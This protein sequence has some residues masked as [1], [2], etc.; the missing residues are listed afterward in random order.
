MPEHAA[1]VAA[2]AGG[3]GG[4]GAG[5]E[6]RER[7]GELPFGEAVGV[8]ARGGAERPAPGRGMSGAGN[9]ALLAAF[10]LVPLVLLMLTSFVKVSVVLSLAR[11]AIGAPDAPSGLVVLGVS[12]ILTFFVMAPVAVDMVAAA[13]AAAPA[14]APAPDAPQPRGAEATP[15]TPATPGV[16]QPRSAETP[17]GTP[18]TSGTSGADGAKL[19]FGG[20]VR[21]L[22]PAEYHAQVDAAERAL[23]PLQAF[24]AKHAAQADRET[25]T[26]LAERMGRSARGDELWVLAPA[27][28][29]TELREAFAIAVLLFIPFLVVDL[30]VGLGLAALGLNAT[31]PQTVAL[32][33]KLLLFVT[34]DGWRML[35]DSLLRGYV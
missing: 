7:G 1:A 26:N 27:F 5:V 33:L 21:A 29:A 17:P 3:E 19:D 15:P 2:D 25:F 16:P 34:V 12:L 35:L 4:A 24:L 30:V 20:A 23:G 18:G 28:L 8:A 6:A 31:S 10:A 13:T 11:N 9:A 32:P 22:V 14:P